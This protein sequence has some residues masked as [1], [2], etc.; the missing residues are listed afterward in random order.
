MRSN[1]EC[2]RCGCGSIL[3]LRE[4][5]ARC[6]DKRRAEL[7]ASGLGSVER[8]RQSYDNGQHQGNATLYKKPRTGERPAWLD[9]G[10]INSVVR[11][12]G[13]LRDGTPPYQRSELSLAAEAA[14][15]WR[16]LTGS[17][18]Y[19]VATPNADMP[20][21]CWPA[22]KDPMA[23][24][25][26]LLTAAVPVHTL[27]KNHKCRWL[28]CAPISGGWVF[29]AAQEQGVRFRLAGGEVS[30]ESRPSTEQLA[31]EAAE[32]AHRLTGRV[33]YAVVTPQPEGGMVYWV[34]D[35]KAHQCHWVGGA[36]RSVVMDGATSLRWQVAGGRVS[37]EAGPAHSDAVDAMQYMLGVDYGAG[38][39]GA[40]VTATVFPGGV[41]RVDDV[42][43][44]PGERFCGPPTPGQAAER[45]Q[46]WRRVRARIEELT[47]KHEPPAVGAE[48][49]YA[50]ALADMTRR[51]EARYSREN[52]SSRDVYRCR[53]DKLEFYYGYASAWK[54]SGLDAKTLA[55]GVWRRLA[56]ATD[57]E[58]PAIGDEVS[59]EV[60]KADMMRRREARYRTNIPQT[61][62]QREYTWSADHGQG[63]LVFRIPGGLWEGSQ[64][65]QRDLEDPLRRWVRLA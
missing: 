62:W 25:L 40:V 18:P 46:L 30:F 21:I 8:P 10:G 52:G 51:Q 15:A 65:S 16:K 37:V 4:S 42:R 1:M 45:D 28:P 35:G 55:T 64:L 31:S 50:T 13:T 61:G 54:V 38:D 9:A 19:A 11:G 20:E 60:A 33:P 34:L 26:E 22:M 6:A 48:V 58:P 12:A 27:P 59:W 41:Y 43:E 5:C 24:S 29:P 36:E 32:Q 39:K 17:V 57:N 23:F 3:S 56:D 49:D 63:S 47:T 53:G 7:H 44:L 14:E 2:R